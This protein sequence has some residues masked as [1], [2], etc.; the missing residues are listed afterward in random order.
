M[1][2]T[3]EPNQPA[4]TANSSEQV[5]AASTPAP[6]VHYFSAEDKGPE[7]PYR[8]LSILALIGFGV[9]VLYSAFV[10]QLGL[11]AFF[12]HKPLMISGW[13]VLVPVLALL[14]C[15]LAGVR[16]RRSEGTLAGAALA[17]WG[18]LLSLFVGV[19]FHAYAAAVYFAVRQQAQA[20]T[21]TWLELIRRNELT[22]AVLH[23]LP[24]NRHPDLADLG[25]NI[26]EKRRRIDKLLRENEGFASLAS[27][28]RQHILVRVLTQE[29]SDEVRFESRGVRSWNYS[30]GGYEVSFTYNITTPDGVFEAIITVHSMEPGDGQDDTGAAQTS[31]R[32]WFLLFEKTSLDPEQSSTR[33]TKRG[34]ATGNLYQAGQRMLLDWEVKM[35]AHERG[36]AFLLTLPEEQRPE[37][38]KELSKGMRVGAVGGPLAWTAMPTGG[39][40]ERFARFLAGD[41]VAVD[42]EQ[43][44]GGEKNRLAVTAQVRERFS[45]SQLSSRIELGRNPPLRSRV[46]DKLVLAYDVTITSPARHSADGSF[47]IECDPAALDSPEVPARWRIRRL[48][49]LGG[50]ASDMPPEA[51]RRR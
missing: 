4:L 20:Y 8:A 29:G 33:L 9:G 43:F 45:A 26:A 44:F 38:R 23:S 19:C 15:A 22:D 34:E 32:Q 28:F 49:L 25:D 18:L 36:E 50:G 1:A 6:A 51:R 17:R 41:L 14:L 3:H 37:A 24:P 13:S 48:V 31:R 10:A 39:T 7:Q 47:E 16:I 2:E 40:A 35:F 42:P 21:E 11:V 5:E 27:R 46:G 30:R 12:T